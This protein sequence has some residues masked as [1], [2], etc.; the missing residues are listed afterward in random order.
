MCRRFN[1]LSFKYP[2]VTNL[3]KHR[4]NF[5]KPYLHT[6]IDFTGN[7]FVKDSKG[8][9]KM[10]LLIF[11]CLY[12]R[13]VHIELVPDMDTNSL[14]L[15]IIRFTNIY[16]VPSHIYSDNAKSF[17]AGCD[18]MKEIFIASE[19]CEHYSK[20]NIKH[21]RIPTYSAWV[22]STWERMIRV[23]KSCLYK[24]IGRSTMGY[25]RLLTILSDIQN[26]VN[27]RPL[28]YRCSDDA[29]LEIITPNCFIKPYVNDSL[30]FKSNNESILVTGGP[31]RQTVTQ[32]PVNR[33]K[34]LEEFRNLW[35]EEYL[36]SLR[37]QWSNL[38]ET[39]FVN[40]VKV[41][42]V[43]LVKGPPDKKRLYWRLGRILEL[44]P[45]SDGK[46]RSVRLKRGDGDI[47]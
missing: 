24:L 6:G 21:I 9:K 2:K 27:S 34:T 35:Y 4:L 25:Y 42:D 45:G 39:N 37:E 3:P 46:V 28:T 16:G 40:R 26:A 33:D 12:V 13:A 43:V 20:Y 8:F 17:I 23:I 14:V 5:I 29:G 15:A 36:L 32:S 41:D 7:V 19:F 47:A 10:Y 30:L 11:T 44:L 38:H 18:V 22:G 31:T 1:S